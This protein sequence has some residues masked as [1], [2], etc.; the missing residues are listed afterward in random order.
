[1]MSPAPPARNR[2]LIGCLVPVAM[3]L[4]ALS[5]CAGVGVLA[6][7]NQISNL[8]Q[9]EQLYGREDRPLI[10]ERLILQAAADFKK[11]GNEL[12]LGDAYR[13]YADLL[14]AP[15][16]SGKWKVYYEQHG[17][18]DGSTTY[19]GRAKAAVAY[20]KKA[21]VAYERAV[22]DLEPRQRYD[23]LT[24][25]YY[26]IGYTEALLGDTP[27]ACKAYNN[28]LAAFHANVQANPQSKPYSPSGSVSDFIGAK[29]RSL[30][31]PV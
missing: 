23:A 9:A 31:C 7:S 12:G 27:G 18:L 16:T 21:L 19:D 11:S 17:F 25:A 28:A 20:R 13:E 10:A 6:S 29:M 14:V 5:G 15:S 4:V 30:G 22:A 3:V 26:N 1:M 2:C 8:N 24:N